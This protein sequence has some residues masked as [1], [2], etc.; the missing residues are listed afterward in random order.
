MQDADQLGCEAR[1]KQLQSALEESCDLPL[2]TRVAPG[3][4]SSDPQEEQRAKRTGLVTDMSV[5]NFAA[6]SG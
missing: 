5:P 2:M 3:P 4:T 6:P 1:F